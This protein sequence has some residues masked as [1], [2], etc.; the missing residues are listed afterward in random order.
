MNNRLFVTVF[1]TAVTNRG[2]DMV[3]QDGRP[4][5]QT[6]FH[7][8][9]NRLKPIVSAE[10]LVDG[11]EVVSQGW[12]RDLQFRCN[13]PRILRRRKEFQYPPFLLGEGLD[14]SRPSLAVAHGKDLF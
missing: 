12:Q 9:K 1:R 2:P 14:G 3:G 13:L 8:M 10:L 4:L 6:A 7:G 5:D 11:V